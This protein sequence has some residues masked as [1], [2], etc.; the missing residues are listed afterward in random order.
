MC[1]DRI[2]PSELSKPLS[3]Q[4]VSLPNGKARAVFFASKLWRNGTALRIGFIGGTQEQQDMV[5]E[6][7]PQWT[8]Y[9]NLKFEFVDSSNATIRIAFRNDG[10]W[11]YIGTDALQI[12]NQP[13]MNFGWLNERVILHEFGH[14]IGM[15]HEHQNPLDNPIQWDREKVIEDLSGPPN[16]WDIDTIERNMFRRYSMSQINGSSFDPESIML[17]SFPS[18]WTTNGFSTDLNDKLSEVDKAF[19]QRVYPGNTNI[20]NL[21]VLEGQKAKIGQPGEEDLYKFEVEF[22][23]T[24][25]IETKGD[26]DLV[27]SLFDSSDNLIT[28]ND[29]SGIDRNPRIVQRL[30]AGEYMIQVRHYNQ[31][32]GTGEYSISIMK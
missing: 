17:Y 28:Q 1:F 11:S 3:D 22:D 21:P 5:K 32:Q 2:L 31:S 25:V 8:E 26:V 12:V 30:S 14:M 18:S 9:A 13:T 20:V 6:V 19:A 29:D 7:A 16:Y 24:Y 23:D 4:I 27:M 15:V 10:A